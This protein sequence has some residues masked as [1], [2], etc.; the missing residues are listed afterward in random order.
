MDKSVAIIKELLR[1]YY[2]GE[3][4]PEEETRLSDLLEAAA[5]LPEELE[6]DKAMFCA[7]KNGVE[8][9]EAPEWLEARISEAIDKRQTLSTPSFRGRS[10]RWVRIVTAISA[11]A[12]ILLLIAI[13]WQH[14]NISD[15]QPHASVSLAVESSNS[16]GALMGDEGRGMRE[17]APATVTKQAGLSTDAWLSTD[18]EESQNKTDEQAPGTR[19]TNSTR[20]NTI[21]A[22]LSKRAIASSAS[23]DKAAEPVLSDD[24][25][26]AMKKGLAMLA[27]SGKILNLSLSGAAQSANKSIATAESTLREGLSGLK[28]QL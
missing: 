10:V 19:L 22:K 27:G 28:T 4:S 16:S 8:E 3:T 23:T 5:E 21:A 26:L 15:E 11:A 14:W 24:E 9:A 25:E 20:T 7:L 18:Q 1:K 13:P 17:Q 6:A 2:A 12:A